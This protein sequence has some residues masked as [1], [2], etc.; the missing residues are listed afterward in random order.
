MALCWRRLTGS[1]A[2]GFG[3][4]CV[5]R[6]S[7]ARGDSAPETKA[8]YGTI[9]NFRL[10]APSGNRATVTGRLPPGGL[11]VEM[12]PFTAVPS[13]QIYW[14]GARKCANDAPWNIATDT[15]GR[16]IDFDVTS[17]RLHCSSSNA[18][19]ISSGSE[20]SNRV[21]IHSRI[22]WRSRLRL[23]ISNMR[24]TMCANES[25]HS[26]GS[27][28]SWIRCANCDHGIALAAKNRAPCDR[29]ARFC[30][31][32]IYAEVGLTH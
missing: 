9:V 5:S 24:S 7:I 32:R 28:S 21:D 27:R 22:D 30:K 13:T 26:S 25:A 19:G 18:A 11:L 3:F 8:D 14:S 17:S 12:H 1:G 10:G 16:A 2:Q 23:V 31:H 20:E 15:S 29:V 6:R 4:G